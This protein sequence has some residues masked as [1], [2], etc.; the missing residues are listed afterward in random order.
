MSYCKMKDVTLL[1]DKKNPRHQHFEKDGE[2]EKHR[3][4]GH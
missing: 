3:E 1:A 4:N 2:R